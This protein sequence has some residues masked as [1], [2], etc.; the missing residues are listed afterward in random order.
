MP[1]KFKEIETELEKTIKK[2]G[3]NTEAIFN[4]GV[5]MGRE[6][7]KTNAPD[8]RPSIFINIEDK[9]KITE[10]ARDIKRKIEK[11]LLSRLRLAITEIINTNYD[12]TVG[13]DQYHS[14]D[15]KF[16]DEIIKK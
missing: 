1:N 4:L 3:T 8:Y 5:K 13:V 16:S 14:G 11:L 12:W 6:L 7:E 2:F 15:G 10:E 9:E